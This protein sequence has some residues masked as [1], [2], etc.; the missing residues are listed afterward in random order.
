MDFYNGKDLLKKCQEMGK[1]TFLDVCWDA[2]G[3]WGKVLDCCLPY[4]DFFMPSIDEAIQLADGKEDPEEIADVFMAKGAKNVIIKL[5]KRGSFLRRAGE[6]KGKIFPIV[7]RAKPVDTTGAGDSFD[8]AFLCGLLEGM[9][10][11]DAAKLATAAASLNTG[12]FGPMEGAISREN[13]RRLIDAA[14]ME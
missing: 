4:L 13:C 11:L 14:V 1:T 9:S 8:G 5:G 2:K 10:L 6:T 3:N 7:G 12:A